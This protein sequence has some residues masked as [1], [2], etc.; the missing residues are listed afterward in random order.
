ML[1]ALPLNRVVVID[2]ERQGRFGLEHCLH[3]WPLRSHFPFST[4]CTEEEHVVYTI[5]DK[6][7]AEMAIMHKGLQWHTLVSN[8][9]HKS[10]ADAMA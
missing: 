7:E 2:L 5:P 6:V 8:I 9:R 4:M 3:P 1:S 10:E